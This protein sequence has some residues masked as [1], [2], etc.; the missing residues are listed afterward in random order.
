[1][2]RSFNGGE[3]LPPYIKFTSEG[4]STISLID[5]KGLSL[6]YSL[7][8]KTWQIW[9]KST[10]SFSVIYLRGKNRKAFGGEAQSSSSYF[11]LTGSKCACEGNINALID[12]DGADDYSYSSR[13]FAYLFYQCTSLTSAPKLPATRVSNYSY[14]NMFRGCS[15]LVSVPDL[16]AEVLAGNCCYYMFEGCT[17]L[18]SAPKLPATTLALACYSSMFRNCSSLTTVPSLLPATTL[19]TN[20]YYHMFDGCVALSSAPELPAAILANG[21]YDSMFNGCNLISAI[22]CHATDI[23]ANNATNNWLNNVAGIG[24]FYTPSSTQWS[25]GT[26]GIPAGW[27]RHN[28]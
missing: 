27:T 5:S 26:S 18:R 2:R 10:T 14:S 11:R 25:S 3:A 28:L 24:D 9:G 4:T 21:C 19:D 12:Y 8:G 15:S 13:Q 16:S 7:N 20:C 6:E 22:R 23:S 1:M 17:S